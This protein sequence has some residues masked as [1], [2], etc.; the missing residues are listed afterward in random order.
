MW[1]QLPHGKGTAA[2]PLFGP[3]LLCL[4]G[5]PPSQQLLSFCSCC[6]LVVVSDSQYEGCGIQEA[7]GRSTTNEVKWTISLVV[8]SALNSLQRSDFV[9]YATGWESSLCKTSSWN[10]S[11]LSKDSFG[12]WSNP[13]DYTVHEKTGPLLCFQITFTNIGQYQ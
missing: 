8:I 6:H 13:E 4:N 12:I 1:T 11:I 3:C 2:P 7:V 9:G 5:H 10:W